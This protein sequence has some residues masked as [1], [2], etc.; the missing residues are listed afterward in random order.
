MAKK[1]DHKIGITDEAIAKVP[2]IQ[3]KEIP[4]EE[5]DII[6][7]LAVRV[8]TLSKEKNDSNEVSIT[9]CLEHER[10]LKNGEKFIGVSFGDEHTVDPLS[11]TI[12]YH[13][14]MSSSE[15]MV[16]SLH[17]HP[18]LSAISVPDIRF[19]L[20][21][22]SIKMIVIV[23][24]LGNVSYL[25]KGKRFDEKKAFKILK[26]TIIL[27]NEATSLKGYQ[28]ATRYFLSNCHEAGIVYEDH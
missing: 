10:L 1:R 14:I 16:V 4:E 2:R 11:D 17:N 20:E 19:F 28:Q 25:V 8:L 18:S 22:R 26:D 13:L 12:S 27:H 21:Y 6:Q 3:Y 23:T 7:R 9:Y 24:N 5:Y 15:C